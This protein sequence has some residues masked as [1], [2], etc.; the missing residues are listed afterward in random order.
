M[1]LLLLPI[2]AATLASTPVDFAFIAR[3]WKATQSSLRSIP[4]PDLTTSPPVLDDSVAFVGR[5]QK[6]KTAG[7]PVSFDFNGVQVKATVANT[8]GLSAYMSQV[9]KAQGNTFQ[10]FL[11][12]VLQ[13][14]SRFNTSAWVAGQV[15]KVPLFAPGS[16]RAGAS[17]AVTIVKDTEPQFAGTAV[18]PNY[19][20]FH[21]F[22]GDAGLR[23]VA[24]VRRG[25]SPQ[26]KVEFLG[27]SITAGFDNQCDIPGSPQ[28]FPW[29]ES[30]VKSWAT[31]ICDQLD[32]EC[33]Y[34][35]WSG[36]GMVANC[37]GG[38]TL[39]SDVWSRTLAT[40]G[41]TN[42]S[43]PHGTTTDN[44]W[45]FGSWKADAVVINLG[46]NDHLGTTKPSAKSDAFMARYKALVVAA[47]QAYGAD[48]HF[49]LACGPMSTDYCMEVNT[50]I[51]QATALGIKAHLLDQR[52]FNNGSYGKLCAFGHPGSEID[53]AMAKNGSAFIKT[54]MG[55][56]HEPQPAATA[57][58][59]AANSVV[60]G[61]VRVTAL[62]STL[63]RVEP[64][65]PNGFED[66]TTFN[67]VGRDA[68]PGLPIAVL[69]T[70]KSGTWLGTSA[71]HVHVPASPTQ[72]CS[73][74][75]GTDADD[76]TRDPSNPDGATATDAGACCDMCVATASCTAWTFAPAPVVEAD[77]EAEEEEEEEEG[78]ANCWLF[79]KVAGTKA[80]EQR[81]FGFVRAVPNVTV[82]TPSGRVL[83]QGANTGNASLVG[84]NLLHWPS[85]LEVPA[86]AF[87]DRPR[88]HVP[89]WGPT[90]I[91]SGASVDP[92]L[93]PTN[94]YDFTNDVAGD[95]Y[96]FLLG[97][98]LPSWW[99]SRGELLAL[100]GPT[101]LLPDFAYGVWYTWYI[102][103]TEQRAK[104]EILNWTAAKLPLDVWALDMNWREIGANDSDA[105]AKACHSQLNDDPKCR[106]HFYS[107]PNLDLMPGL[108][109]PANEWF[110]F[111][112]EQ[113]L[114]TYFNDPVADQ[115][116]P[117]EV[118][119]RYSGI[120]EW[121]GRGLSYWW[122]DH[123]WA[124]TLPGPLQPFN[125][126]AAYEGLSGQVWGSHVYYEA[127]KAAYAEHKIADRPLALTRDNGP[128]WREPEPFEQTRRGAGSPAHHRYPVWWTGDKVPLMASVEAMVNEAVHDL[129]A[130]V[131]S[132]CGGHGDRTS[133]PATM[134]GAPPEGKACSTPNDAALLRWTAHCVLGTVVRFHQGDHRFW[135][136]DAPTQEAARSYL[137]LRHTLAPSLIAAGRTLQAQGFPLTA[138]CDLLWP[139]HAAA[140]DPTQYVHLN[141]TLVAPLDVEPI[142]RVASSRTVWIPPGEWVDGWSGA[143]VH[144]PTTLNVTQPPDRIP[145]WHRRGALLVT[146]PRK[147]LRLVEQ[148]W[149]ELTIEAFP[150]SGASSARRD[151]FEQEGAALAPDAD[152]APTTIELTSRG[153]G[154]VA[155]AVGASPVARAWV[156]RLHLHA[157]AQRLALV[158]DASSV[159]AGSLRHLLPDCSRRHFPLQ[160]EGAAPPCE[161]GA[162]AELRLAPSKEARR[163][164]ARVA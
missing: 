12:G 52:D 115:A 164:E 13:P 104:D 145:M 98:D 2:A 155:L 117:K 114:R 151:L 41:S 153:D 133:C 43:D 53:A 61:D 161:A 10:V 58:T 146:A 99:R 29:S 101:P 126:S 160:G 30:F 64:R 129:R 60:V 139:E 106:D 31:L 79:S 87:E 59:A 65:G 142:D 23:L 143:A 121:I 158:G 15:I 24:P 4:A 44:E 57:S 67:V 108:A 105:S 48:T 66:R 112:K 162:I 71:F 55:W 5:V 138:R 56:Q 27:D 73:P 8:T 63:V 91:P 103:Y 51:D 1:A 3:E 159:A 157:A 70:S 148:D 120:S 141:A 128:N 137:E 78:G 75:P 37:C 83:W 95:T 74:Q 89:A 113:R 127:T 147:G 18:T 93:L 102:R 82:A 140:R 110:A 62:S 69:N 131:H 130:F 107:H 11:D 54:T 39:G 144:G 122:F 19:V 109:S 111:I 35:A 85:P 50:V 134:S 94:G 16:L 149:G 20:T 100:T 135:L 96:I 33:H 156:V 28:G 116:T 40:V 84:T 152:D 49:F 34:N 45:D 46:T 25:A 119:F 124:F 77:E 17:H 136:R 21:G 154:T 123:N 36:F 132:D 80:H 9:E 26:P 90:P 81:V 32:A 92:A 14:D 76:P 22:G 163:I 42:T 7:G 38:S 72:Q 118:N 125:T 86:Y 97:D 6:A 88:F 68:L 47:S 150:T